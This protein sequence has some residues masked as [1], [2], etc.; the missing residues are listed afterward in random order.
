VLKREL[1]FLDA[2]SAAWPPRMPVVLSRPEVAALMGEL[3]DHK[4]VKATTIYLRVMNKL[5]LAVKSPID[6]LG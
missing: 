3:P 1:G 2:V 5:G 6:V 4:D